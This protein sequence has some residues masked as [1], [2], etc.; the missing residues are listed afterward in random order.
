MIK[1][2]EAVPRVADCTKF[3]TDSAAQSGANGCTQCKISPT[4]P[5]KTV[6]M[7]W[8][9]PDRK[10]R[11]CPGPFLTVGPPSRQFEALYSRSSKEV[12]RD[13]NSV[14]VRAVTTTIFAVALAFAY[15]KKDIDPQKAIQACIPPTLTFGRFLLAQRANSS[16]GSV[17]KP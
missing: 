6:P 7:P 9:L 11:Q 10:R 14:F 15:S 17:S 8:A 1:P 5:L 12:A 4:R 2:P 3:A 16:V 13:R